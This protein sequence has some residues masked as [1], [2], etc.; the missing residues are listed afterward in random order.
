MAE[1]HQSE[2]GV[3]PGALWN[4]LASTSNQMWVALLLAFCALY[5][6]F[7]LNY[8]WRYWNI[9]NYDFPTFYAASVA[10]F[11]QGASP[12]D[13]NDLRRLLPPDV[14]A[15]PFLYPPPGLLFLYPLS[16]LSYADARHV[17][18]ILN[19]V[20]F[21]GLIWAIPFSLLRARSGPDLGVV[22]FCTAFAL[23]FYPVAIT[24][25][26]GQVN[27]LCLSFI[28]LFWVLARKE[29]AVL[30]GFFLAA[31]IVLKTYPMV[32]V[33]LLLVIGRWRECASA[34][35][36]VAAATLLSAA[37]LPPGV[38]H[39]WLTLVLP[40]GGYMN[41]PAGLFSPAAEWNQSLNGMF[42]RLFTESEWSRPVLVNPTAG[43]L[44]TYG[45]AALTT[46]ISLVA[47]WRARE[48]PD[49]LD[50]MVFIALPLMFL[51]A[52]FSWQHHLVFLLPV[53]LVLLGALLRSLIMTRA[54]FSSTPDALFFFLCVAA[55]APMSCPVGAGYTS[56]SGVSS[57]CGPRASSW[58]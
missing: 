16:I 29:K 47:T 3:H 24:L 1:A 17:V 27:I 31:A 15:L 4:F 48:R 26:N 11:A 46:A 52:P 36:F 45:A 56:H 50:R 41:T 19:H 21:L 20:L 18:L 22:A 32:F 53:V 39:D 34:V 58:R 13:F 2:L 55:A 51:I 44:A 57:F 25:K 5:F 43:R 12:Y 7:V 14:E 33:P 54:L 42:A 10:V 23:G 37:I 49:S 35:G 38:W 9:P 6:Q 40:S 8:G 28:V 30:A